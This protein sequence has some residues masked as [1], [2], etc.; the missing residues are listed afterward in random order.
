MSTPSTCGVGF[1]I[2]AARMAIAG[3]N[4]AAATE[5]FAPAFINS[6]RFNF[7]GMVAFL[8]LDG[9]RTG[10]QIFTTGQ[11]TLSSKRRATTFARGR[12]AVCLHGGKSLLLLRALAALLT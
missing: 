4:A 12:T 1:V 11:K 10:L 8:M 2:C 5:A 6:L 7:R 9:I 3:P